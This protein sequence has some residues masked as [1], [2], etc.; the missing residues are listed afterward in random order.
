MDD[1]SL[2]VNGYSINHSILTYAFLKEVKARSWR[3]LGTPWEEPVP[4]F[5]HPGQLLWLMME[6]ERVQGRSIGDTVEI[7]ARAGFKPP[8]VEMLGFSIQADSTLPRFSL[9]TNGDAY[10]FNEET[11][12]S[13]G[14]DSAPYTIAFIDHPIQEL[15]MRIMHRMVTIDDARGICLI[16]LKFVMTSSL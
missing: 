8:P 14:F 2:P 5:M 15:K 3:T 16:G 12:G 7:Y 1:N 6:Q 10:D 11:P 9:V 4:M 13:S